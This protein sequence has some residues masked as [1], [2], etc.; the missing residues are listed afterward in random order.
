MERKFIYSDPYANKLTGSDQNYN[1]RT[2]TSYEVDKNNK[3]ISGTQETKLLYAPIPNQ[4]RTPVNQSGQIG[5]FEKGDENGKNIKFGNYAIA[6]ESDGGKP[7]KFLKYT[8]TDN[9][10]G[11][12]PSGNKVGDDVLGET[13]KKSLLANDGVFHKGA[14]NSVINSAVKKQPGLSAVVT[15][16]PIKPGTEPGATPGAATP[17]AADTDANKKPDKKDETT[18]AT[19]ATAEQFKA[20]ADAAK[21]YVGRKDYP[22]NLKYPVDMNPN[23]DCIQFAVIE[24]Q[25][26]KLGLDS[27]IN[28]GLRTTTR[29][30][31]T[32]ITLPMPRGISD[33]NSVSW[34]N[35]ELNSAQDAL[36]DVAMNAVLGGAGAGADSAKKNLEAATAGNKNLLAAIIA[37]KASEDAVGTNNLLSRAFGVEL[38]PNMELLFNGPQLRDFSFSF[39]MNPRSPTEAKMVRSIIRT[40]KQA[41]SVKRSTSV[42]LLKSPHTFMIKYITS[43][44]EHPYLNRFKECALT[45]CSVEYTPDGQY[46]SYDS[47]DIDE[48]SMTAYELSL[49]FNELEPIFDDDYDD[50]N[51]DALPFTNI[52]Y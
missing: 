19:P 35:G 4:L 34:Q 14:T 27:N 20:I 16:P 48:R 31:L 47:G 17:G 13:A 5:G 51:K 25:A 18:A 33:R 22:Q 37:A 12:I 7:Y 26:S 44:K 30:A 40:F 28:T 32:T 9:K 8:D 41:M 29:K 42:L 21:G 36:A 1:F 46:M 15:A 38:N 2:I 45:N 10:N 39:R 52:G 24:Y 3:P 49:S 6:A 23:Q 43:N 11:V 50:K